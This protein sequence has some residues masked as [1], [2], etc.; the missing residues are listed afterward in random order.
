MLPYERS[1]VLL[2]AALEDVYFAGIRDHTVDLDEKA[3]QVL[4]KWISVMVEAV[5]D[6]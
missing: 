4:S 6:R 1:L 3:K 2:R 5:R